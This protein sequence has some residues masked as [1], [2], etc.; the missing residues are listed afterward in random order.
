MLVDQDFP[1]HCVKHQLASKKK[2]LWLV[3]CLLVYI[4]LP[5]FHMSLNII[6]TPKHLKVL[7]ISDSCPFSSCWI[8]RN[9]DIRALS[10]SLS[11]K[12]S[13]RCMKSNK[14]NQSVLSTPVLML[15]T[16]EINFGFSMLLS[17]LVFRLCVGSSRHSWWQ[18][19][20]SRLSEVRDQA[21][22]CVQQI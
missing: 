17:S 12:A 16:V 6:S 19:S 2:I 5:S 7:S 10:L 15:L 14:H 3:T 21:W 18:F 20:R 4:F 22:A 13:Q 1:I 9:L 8:S 11:P